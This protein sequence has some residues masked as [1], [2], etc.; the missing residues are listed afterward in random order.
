M[1]SLYE[2]TDEINEL[3]DLLEDEEGNEA[4]IQKRLDELNED[5]EHKF[6]GYMKAYRNLEAREKAV[7]EEAGRLKD[8]ADG[9]KKKKEKIKNALLVA[10]KTTG[11][12]KIETDL[13]SAA[14]R[15][16]APSV[17]VD[18]ETLVPKEFWKPQ[19]DKLDTKGLSAFL[20]E[21]GNK[22]FEYAHLECSTSII[23]K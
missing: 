15:I 4:E 23:F 9:F 22:T 13:F 10:M 11:K 12:K 7:K 20:K 21:N 19:P 18:D 1:A 5:F 2:I 16:N 14:I 8:R 17:V 3:I 6:D